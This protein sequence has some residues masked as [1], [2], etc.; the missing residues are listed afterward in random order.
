MA[1]LLSQYPS[2]TVS[3]D[4]LSES[5]FDSVPEFFVYLL[6]RAFPQRKRTGGMFRGCGDRLVKASATW[7]LESAQTLNGSITPSFS[8]YLTCVVTELKDVELCVVHAS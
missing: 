5:N 3:N 7:S 6:Y 1:V 8:Y 4:K 2:H